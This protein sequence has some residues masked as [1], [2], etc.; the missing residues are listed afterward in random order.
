MTPTPDLERASILLTGASGFV[1]GALLP[2]LTDLGPLRCLVRDATRLEEG[3][4]S[5]A[6]EADLSKADSLVPALEGMDEVYYLVHS[7]EPGGG[8]SVSDR[9]RVAAENYARMAI[10]AGVKRTI[11]LGGVGADNDESEHL[12]SRREVERILQDA[13]TEFVALR[14]S[15]IVGAGSASFGTLVRIVSRLPV[16]A[17]PTWRDRRTQPVAIDD[18][19][20][21]LVGA[22]EV[23]PGIYEIGGPDMLTFEEMTE[24]IADL[25]GD[26]HRSISLPFSSSK[27]EAL[28]AS[29]VTGGDRDLLE[30]LMAGL[31]GDLLVRH[32][33]LREVFGVEPTP[34]AEAAAA[35]IALMPDSELAETA[36]PS[37]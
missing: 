30:P 15:M 1:G 17:L 19:V 8:E 12:A 2:A 29:A 7:M 27:L 26:K 24:V 36:R 11:Y 28:A 6:V 18:V 34:F 9:D 10:K 20:A 32:N 23:E 33:H 14:A 5:L 13:S 37:D 35:A 4:R 16:L 21:C 3:V 22:R 25:L 31:D